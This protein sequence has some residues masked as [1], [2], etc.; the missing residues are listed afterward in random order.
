MCRVV[1]AG[2]LLDSCF[3]FEVMGQATKRKLARKGEKWSNEQKEYLKRKGKG[4]WYDEKAKEEFHRA[5]EE[6]VRREEKERR[7]YEIECGSD[8]M[9]YTFFF[10]IRNSVS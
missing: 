10:F 5:E 7:D 6:R 3:W 9:A 2:T 1:F 8:N 4:G